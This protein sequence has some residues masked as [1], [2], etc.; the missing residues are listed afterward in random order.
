M[1]RPC[2]SGVPP[3]RAASQMAASGRPG[4]AA[5]FGPPRWG[6]SRGAADEPRQ[7]LDP[8]ANKVGCWLRPP[9]GG[10]R[11]NRPFA[12][13]AGENQVA[14]LRKEEAFSGCVGAGSATA[15]RYA[16]WAVAVCCWAW[17]RPAGRAEPVGIEVA[18]PIPYEERGAAHPFPLRYLAEA[19]V[20]GV[21][22][23]AG[24]RLPSSPI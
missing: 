22:N 4:D 16:T 12:Q 17:R 9:R 13:E 3:N 23:G 2:S 18:H 14:G 11:P 10:L 6:D 7:T 8:S 21:L 1:V 24:V 5:L 15:E 19:A 20:A